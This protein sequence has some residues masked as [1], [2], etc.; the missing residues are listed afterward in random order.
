MQYTEQEK[1]LAK[2]VSDKELIVKILTELIKLN[3]K[4]KK[5]KNKK[6]DSL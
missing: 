1:I 6:T 5:T 4:K 2:Y 3:C